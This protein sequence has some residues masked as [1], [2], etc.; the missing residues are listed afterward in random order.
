MAHADDLINELPAKSTQFF[1]GFTAGII[2]QVI[3]ALETLNDY[4]FTAIGKSLGDSLAKGVMTAASH[5]AIFS[6][7][8]MDIFSGENFID[9]LNKYAAAQVQNERDDAAAAEERKR[10]READAAYE[11]ARMFEYA[12]APDFVEPSAAKVIQK[13]QGTPPFSIPQQD[14]YMRR[15]LSLSASPTKTTE[16]K[17][18]TVLE[19]IEKILA[20]AST[21]GELVWR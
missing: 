14:E 10:Q 13:I 16:E 20:R 15:G 1:T 9:S 6:N 11:K 5:L 17:Q 12:N 19:K 7:A 4:E 18:L 2:G 8:A 3:P 21:N